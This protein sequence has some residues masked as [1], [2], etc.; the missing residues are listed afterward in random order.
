VSFLPRLLGW[1]PTHTQGLVGLALLF[2]L[3]NAPKPLL[4]DDS[5]YYFYAKQIAQDP[6]RPYAFHMFW[7]QHPSPAN[8]ILAPPGLPYWWAIAY[9]LF[10]EQ[11]FWW[12]VWLLPYS[13]IFVFALDALFR[14]FARGLETPLVWMTVLSPTFLPSLNLMLDVPALA[15]VLGSVALFFRSC[16]RE[17]FLL[18]GAAGLV[19]GLAMETKYTAFMAPAIILLYAFMFRRITLGILASGV[20]L[21]VFVYWEWFIAIY[22]GESHFICNLKQ[23][24]STLNEKFQLIWPLLTIVGA[25]S[26]PVSLLGLAALGLRRASLAVIGAVMAIGYLV[27]ACFDGVFI[28]SGNPP[29]PGDWHEPEEM[30]LEYVIFGALGLVSLG[31]T[32][33]GIWCLCVRKRDA[34]VDNPFSH[35]PIAFVLSPFRRMDLFLV[36]WLLGEMAGYFLLTPF[37]AVRRV[38]GVM[39]VGTLLAGRLAARTCAAWPRRNVIHGVAAAS[40]ALGVL[41]YSVDLL[42]AFAEKNAAEGA[43]E[44]IRERQPEARIWYVGHWGFQY[45]A[46]RAGM[47]PVVPDQSI[48]G[49]GD[50]L[51]KPGWLIR[52]PRCGHLNQQLIRVSRFHTEKVIDLTVDD[53]LPLRTVQNFYGGRAP[54]EHHEGPRVEVTIYRITNEWRPHSP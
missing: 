54:L 7:Y 8:E 16:A 40:V 20:A 51:V 41:F 3:L 48:L 44:F 42:D 12:K 11:P 15:L 23:Q 17:S 46:E 32:L 5:A 13:L 9:G 53:R 35:S 31:V 47:I 50:W 14:R 22:H 6:L 26:P 25:L 52:W 43:A 24:D 45:Y 49:E 10:G 34:G 39:V 36:L 27:L 30:P 38:M 37:P 4:V 33:V 2:T 21:L 19:A 18:A 28:L 29:L 1:R